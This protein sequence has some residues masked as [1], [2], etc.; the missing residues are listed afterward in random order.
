[1]STQIEEDSGDRK[2]HLYDPMLDMM[3][4]VVRKLEQEGGRGVLIA[5]DWPAQ[6]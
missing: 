2:A 5:A 6:P 3:P 1:M 4:L